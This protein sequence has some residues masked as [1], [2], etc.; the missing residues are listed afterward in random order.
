M[1]E[2]WAD[3]VNMLVD[4]AVNNTCISHTNINTDVL[5]QLFSKR[6]YACTSDQSVHLV[7]HLIMINTARVHIWPPFQCHKRYPWTC[8]MWGDRGS[9]VI[10]FSTWSLSTSAPKYPWEAILPYVSQW[11]WRLSQSLS[12][13]W[14]GGLVSYK[15]TKCLH[16]RKSVYVIW[17]NIM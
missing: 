9:H 10:P 2:I 13:I 15:I 7:G 17:N 3:V 1:L 4:L 14:G 16:A 11:S 5:E 6:Q 12:S 8:G